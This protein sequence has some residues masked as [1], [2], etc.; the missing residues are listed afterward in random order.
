VSGFLWQG[1]VL[2][3]A[4]LYWLLASI[5]SILPLCFFIL[6]AY[7]PSIFF[8]SGLILFTSVDRQFFNPFFP[9]AGSLLSFWLRSGLLRLASHL[10]A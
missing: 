10:E 1:W 9:S 3:L 5:P 6:E 8:A 7:F 4:F 2:G